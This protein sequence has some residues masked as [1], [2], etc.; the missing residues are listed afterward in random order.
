MGQVPRVPSAPSAPLVTVRG[1]ADRG[2]AGR[3]PEFAVRML[4]YSRTE[5]DEFVAEVRRELRALG[6]RLAQGL[7]LNRKP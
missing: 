6:I 5:V 7:P 3:E 2:E 1:M 4:G